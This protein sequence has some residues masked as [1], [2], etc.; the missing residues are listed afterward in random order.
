MADLNYD[1]SVST[2]QAEANLAKLQKSVEG[3]NTT[4]GNLRNVL[5]GISLGAVISQAIRMADA[6]Q[7]L[8]DATE[9]STATIL[10]FTR[11]VQANGG[12]AEAAQKG[13]ARLVG[14]IDEAANK[15]GAGRSAFDDVGISLNDLR[16]LSAEDIFKRTIEGLGRIDDVTKRAS[17]S[18][19]LLGKEFRS[20]NAQ[21]VGQGF[22]GSVTASREYANSIKSAADA[23][24]KLETALNNL[25][26]A[27]LKAV[28]PLADFVA[29]IDLQKLDIFVD[30]L[31]KISAAF[32]GL[33]VASK[34]AGAV[35]GLVDGFRMLNGGG[36]KATGMMGEAALGLKQL[37]QAFDINI[38]RTVASY[39]GFSVLGITLKS[40]AGG[41]LRLV[42]IVGAAFAAFQLLDGAV[43]ILTGRSLTGWLDSAAAS[44]ESF[45]T[46]SFPKLAAAINSLGKTLGMAPPPSEVAAAEKAAKDRLANLKEEQA[47]VD[48]V[49]ESQAKL[50]RG[51]EA[52]AKLAAD[53]AK[54]AA[55]YKLVNAEQARGTQALFDS[56][57]FQR[58]SVG[59]TEDELEVRTRV[60]EETDRY[61]SAVQSLKD[62]QASLRA[63]M[64][65]EKDADKIKLIGNEI[66]LING[67]LKQAEGLHQLNKKQIEEQIP[68]IQGLR[69]VEAARKQDIENTTR[70]IEDQLSRQQ[71]LG[72][73]L[74]SANDQAQAARNATPASQLT[75]LSSIQKQIVEIQDSA[76]KAA[77]EAAKSFAANFEDDGD[78]LT[79]ER[80]RELAAG[81]DK[82]AQAYKGVAVA[83]TEVAQS[84][85]ETSRSFS[86]GWTDAFAKYAEDAQNAAEQAA[87][88]FDRFTKGFEDAVVALVTNGKFSFKDFANS[89][90]ADFAR[91][92]ARKALTSFM[93]NATPG[94]SVLGS[95]FNYGKSLFGFANGGSVSAGIPAIVGE[96]GPE[97][98]MPTNAGKIIANNQ[99]GQGQQVVHTTVNYAIQAVDASSFRSLVARDPS[100][101]Y[102][103]TEQGRRSQPTRRSA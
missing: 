62:K 77:N 103:V 99:L 87:T 13:L 97:L 89:I 51:Q 101:I 65:G 81:L 71:S 85:Y 30:R 100:F 22:A 34:A 1:V 20:V 68:V 48:A 47:E 9:I 76:R 36:V 43:E 35:R 28:K 38:A 83:Q 61:A 63:E 92:E 32:V 41:F 37:G 7:D 74:R 56:L 11:A 98:F 10:G 46:S 50:I 42:P 23:Q 102:A 6:V 78:G 67:T 93:S 2:T 24:Q 72:D 3:I 18:T 17:I 8:S 88:Y 29:Q 14:T 31:I 19:Q 55:A 96:R 15:A 70:A 75:G 90:I 49:R 95:L 73:L 60:K 79:P 5:A 33:F 39:T 4:F 16:T 54:Q 58:D 44:M 25:Q 59:L 66:A 86:T 53:M 40:L 27:L 80:A 64:I 12:S 52:L 94:G 69:L 84:N 45:V 91:I 82:I 57:G 21:G 26:L